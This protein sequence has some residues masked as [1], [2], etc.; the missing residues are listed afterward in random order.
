MVGDAIVED[1]ARDW[2]YTLRLEAARGQDEPAEVAMGPRLAA[3]S[4]AT[5]DLVEA[6]L[7]VEGGIDGLLAAESHG[8]DVQGALSRALVLAA[9]SATRRTGDGYAADARS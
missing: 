6:F 7:D 2:V 9:D 4:L 3:W 8:I 5:A 1:A